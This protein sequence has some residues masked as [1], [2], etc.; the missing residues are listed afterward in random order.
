MLSLQRT[1]R[2]ARQ[3]NPIALHRPRQ[4]PSSDAERTKDLTNREVQ[5]RTV[6]GGFLFEK[7]IL[8]AFQTH[9][10]DVLA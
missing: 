4:T 1:E 2:P 7:A 8:I 9:F 5:F 6:A 10:I 3:R